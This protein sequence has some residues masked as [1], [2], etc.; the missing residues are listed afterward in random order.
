MTW[1]DPDEIK[2]EADN[3]QTQPEFDPA[4]YTVLK[5]AAIRI[6]NDAEAEGE[7]SVGDDRVVSETGHR[8]EVSLSH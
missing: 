2:H 3:A 6:N 4:A 8:P 7:V 1:Y 5:D